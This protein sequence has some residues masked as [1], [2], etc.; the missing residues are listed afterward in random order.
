MF[1][2]CCFVVR[3]DSRKSRSNLKI[4]VKSKIR[5]VQ[6]KKGGGA[7]HGVWGQRSGNLGKVTD[8]RDKILIFNKSRE[9]ASWWKP[10]LI[11]RD[12]RTGKGLTCPHLEAKTQGLCGGAEV[13]EILESG[14]D[15]NL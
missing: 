14:V 4:L 2:L 8:F 7:K 13:R 5:K 3:L 10:G 9:A 15:L 12:L 11:T 1:S 6:K